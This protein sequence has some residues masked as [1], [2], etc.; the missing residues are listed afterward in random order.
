MLE[1]ITWGQYWIAT[2]VA[3]VLY[4]TALGFI[5]YRSNLSAYL[6]RWSSSNQHETIDTP[7]TASFMGKIKEESPLMEEGENTEEK[8]NP[9]FQSATSENIQILDRTEK[10]AN[11][12]AAELS[13]LGTKAG[14][15]SILVNLSGLIGANNMDG[16]LTAF[17]D[18]VDWHIVQTAQDNCDITLDTD[19]LNRI[20]NG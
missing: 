18:V 4:Y 1:K 6:Q 11:L 16:R 19:D 17:R 10:V 2:G 7:G 9:E 3:T 13:R 12:I 5:F 8:D 14:K 15:E 20:W